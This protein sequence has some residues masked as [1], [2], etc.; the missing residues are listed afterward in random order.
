MNDVNDLAG[1]TSYPVIEER[2][3]LAVTPTGL[4]GKRRRDLNQL[5]L[6]AP[7]TAL[8]FQ[9][10]G[11]FIVYD[12]LRHLDGQEDFVLGALTVAVVNLRPHSF[13]A[14][15]ELPSAYH[16]ETFVIRTSFSAVVRDPSEVVRVGAVDL[17]NSLSRHLRKD[18][19]LAAI[20]A[21]HEIEQI[22]DTRI[23]I[24]ARVQSYYGYRSFQVPGLD[25]SLEL[26]E[27]ITPTELKERDRKLRNA[28]VGGEIDMKIQELEFL[29][30]EQN[31]TGEHKLD[32]LS[33]RYEYDRSSR[34]TEWAHLENLREGK[35]RAEIDELA[36][37]LEAKQAEFVLERL[38]QDLPAQLALAVAR[39]E[40]TTLGALEAQ[41]KA[42]QLDLEELKGMLGLALNGNG[43]DFFV[44]DPQTIFDTVIHKIGG[45]QY[46]ALDSAASAGR[47][48]VTRSGPAP[49]ADVPPD[50][51]DFH[52]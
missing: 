26:V 11:R 38:R 18:P 39:G 52:V 3:L 12:E 35:R 5:P 48:A 9:A 21:S 30:R 15:I 40:L 19:K 27:V 42:E 17:P 6:N 28:T 50:E 51:D 8:V 45:A 36:R 32:S 31:I 29:K 14:D 37:Q 46:A 22:A 2:R 7:G 34:Q 24:D 13:Y 23:A 10:D 41:R 25:V 1:R 44:M 33:S 49:G 47:Q 20:C 43:G 16:S 4:F